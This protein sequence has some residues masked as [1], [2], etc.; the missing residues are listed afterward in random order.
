MQVLFALLSLVCLSNSVYASMLPIAAKGGG[1]SGG[2]GRGGGGSSG[3]GGSG[4]GRGGSG[5]TGSSA[6]SYGGVNTGGRTANYFGGGGG[7]AFAL[8]EAS[9]FSG[10]QMGGGVR[11]DVPGT[12]AYG[13][14]YP[15]SVGNIRSGGVAGQPFPFGFW[16]IYWNGHGHSEEYG[17]NATVASQRPG[18]EQV[19]VQ[20]IAN[21][22]TSTW[23]TTEINGVNET[24]WMIGDRE[25]VTTLLSI[26]IDPH[27]TATNGCD[28]Q[29]STIQL[30]QPPSNST[31]FENVIQW[32]RSNS[33]ALAFQ[34][35]NNSYAFSPLNETSDL[36]WNES[37][38]LPD[39]LQYS[40]F[41][42]CIN[43]TISAALPILD[44]EGGSTLSPATTAV[45][46]LCS[47]F[48]ALVCCC[49]CVPCARKIK[50]SRREARERRK[51]EEKL[52]TATMS[53]IGTPSIVISSSLPAKNGSH[54]A[55]ISAW[56]TH[57]ACKS[58]GSD[59][60]RLS[61]ASITPRPESA[62][63]KSGRESFY[64]SR[65]LVSERAGSPEPG[66]S[67]VLYY[68]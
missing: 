46:V 64:S 66:V 7:S 39:E 13:S 10:R 30:F 2:G 11:A 41:L 20:L 15:Y 60:S 24:Y 53:M 57:G 26:L 51:Y 56:R 63:L 45:I 23:N 19:I 55:P 65:T 52:P 21:L 36:G 54:K 49:C 1:A 67:G 61:Y 42:Q 47:V 34:G 35:Y 40:Q 8:S 12:R 58:D 48:G 3:R 33:F 22:T 68:K 59:S 44:A 62:I 43:S 14:G 17:N 50:Q 6:V 27:A 37:T 31:S 4:A 38:P 5:G 32:Y 16:P 28:V 9:V 18:G 25:S 29:N